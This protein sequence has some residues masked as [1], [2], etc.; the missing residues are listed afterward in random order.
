LEPKKFDELM[1]KVVLGIAAHP[2][3]L[4]F[5]ASGSMAKWAS[6]GAKCYYILCTDGSKGS[7]DPNLTSAQLVETRKTE[8]E[9]AAKIIG[10][11]KVYYLDHEDGLLENTIELKKQLVR[12]I[13]EVKPDT[14]VTMNPDM[15]FS[16]EAGYINHPD[17]RAASQAAL[18]AIFPLSRDRLSFPDLAAAGYA[19]HKTPTVLLMSFGQGANFWVDISTTLEQ[20]LAA[21]RAHDS[22]GAGSEET[23]AMVAEWTKAAGA[24]H[25]S[26]QHAESFIR[27]DIDPR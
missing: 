9:A 15:L 1:P 21:L 6:Q 4:D 22:Q 2:D 24:E 7:D 19:A 14:M 10:L 11:E 25:G 17:H 20:K 12:I 18:D 3:D 27:L 8:Q 16:V 26:M 13:R 23:Q 5:G